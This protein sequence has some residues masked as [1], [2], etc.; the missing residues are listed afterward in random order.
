MADEN[1]VNDENVNDEMTAG[2][3]GQRSS[4]ATEEVPNEPTDLN[5]IFSV[6]D[7]QLFIEDDSNNGPTVFQELQADFDPVI[8]DQQVPRLNLAHEILC[9][10]RTR[11]DIL[12]IHNLRYLFYDIYFGDVIRRDTA[13]TQL[14]FEGWLY[15]PIM[16]QWMIPVQGQITFTHIGI[17]G[18]FI[19][20]DN[21]G[22]SLR[23]VQNFLF[24]SDFYHL[25]ACVPN[26][27][28]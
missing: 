14:R 6:G 15:H 18:C 3:E 13:M 5:A 17:Q 22:W 9:C 8:E 12:R 21:I 25:V 20:F 4:E 10:I 19:A 23:Y 11:G 27:Q 26:E 7:P 1:V 28:G 2:P 24:E 16:C